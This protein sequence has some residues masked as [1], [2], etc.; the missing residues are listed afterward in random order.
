V[1]RSA[2]ADR[3]PRQPILWA[4]AAFAAGIVF[5][6]Y[7]WRPPV[8]W[9]AAAVFFA[10]A[11]AYFLRRQKLWQTFAAKGLALSFLF[12]LGALN[13]QLR[14]RP[15]TSAESILA[16]A[17]GR[18]VPVIVHVIA[19]GEIKA[20]LYGGSVQRIDV[21]T[22]VVG[23]PPFENREVRDIP[24]D[25]EQRVSEDLLAPGSN[26]NAP[27]FAG[28]GARAMHDPRS[29][30]AGVRLSIYAK[31][32]A[33]TG[34]TDQKEASTNSTATGDPQSGTPMHAFRYGDR[35]RCLA[36]LRPPR[37]FRNPGAF[38]YEGYLADN[39]IS[40]LGSAK[41]EDVV[42]LPG[43]VGSRVELW[44]TRVHRSVIGMI[45]RLW[46]EREAALIDAA[47]IGESAFI[48]RS[49]KVD[50]QRSGTYHILVVSGMNVSILAA[51]VFWVLRRIRLGD[52]AASV[53]TVLLSVSYAVLTN[54]GAPVWRAVLMMTLYLG[55][56]LLYRDRSML[57]ALGTAALTFLMFDPHALLGAS[58]QL[59]FLAVLIIAGAG[60]PILE[61]T[62][63]PYRQG[64][65]YLEATSYDSRLD[66]S[67]A[68]FRLDLRMIGERLGRFFSKK[69]AF[70]GITAGM[71]IGIAFCDL[72]FISALM[73]A[74]LA[75]PMA[76]YFH[77][78]TV[79]GVPS[80]MT[81]VTLTGVL[82][83]ASLNAIGLG[84]VHP[85]L[86]KIPAWIA[87]LAL[88]GITGTVHTLG[89]HPIA[90][91]R[92]PTP[93]SVTMMFA[94]GSLA[95]AMLLS[96]RRAALAA[97]GL[98][99]LLATAVWMSTCPATPPLHAG[100]LEMTAI[101]VGEGD[102]TLIVSPKGKTL[103][104]DAGGPTGGQQ[105]SEFDFGEDVVSPY[106]WSRGIS[107]LDAVA[108]SHGH[109]DH[110]GGMRSVL[111]NFHPREIWIGTVAGDAGMTNLLAQA[112]QMRIPVARRFRGDEFAW[113]GT[114]I[115]VFSPPRE[116][117]TT[118]RAHN[119]DS[120]VL[121]IG[122]GTTALL[123]EGDAE[124]KME[125]EMAP[126]GPRADLLKVAHHGSLT[127]AT[128]EFLRAVQ[129]RWASISVGFRNS[130]G[131]P[132]M[133]TLHKLE[134]RGVRTYRTD[135]DGAVTFYL[136]GRTISARTAALR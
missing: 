128:P 109:S 35:L 51:V 11:A 85:W 25:P 122:Y 103:L 82:M 86:A 20:A 74:G 75:L 88:D 69:W 37:N 43:F 62:T 72:L 78:A 13:I 38:D 113:S 116:L 111:N 112:E 68:Q 57:S 105:R 5:G 24:A 133:G 48:E 98:A 60:A 134:D 119:N 120:L 19:E 8:W 29:P 47:V 12:F 3:K 7:A 89:M 118:P 44:R 102:S 135:I 77:R 49:T 46:P 17:D 84:Y 96:R 80:N 99:G 10:L 83:P 95:A 34:D 2:Q 55:A 63:Q 22:E 52:V 129:P 79:I 66:P 1:R 101:D 124:K 27:P 70:G 127:S 54:V 45:H 97:A 65:R 50:F 30:R 130:F 39:G 36:K 81:A 131:L 87:A 100:V 16:Y 26:T 32:P 121:Q 56:R 31:A 61:R 41:A 76:Y 23:I 67:I 4:A 15:D 58:F 106:L 91:L 73:Q 64:L 40:A 92:V 14:E 28:E 9:M 94:A 117:Q 132:G 93:A 115:K 33:G 90:D 59:T 110:I 136:D 126:L 125:E 18:E 108:I 123:L 42:L 107:H 53:A 114:E 6:T 21:E 71:R 104:V